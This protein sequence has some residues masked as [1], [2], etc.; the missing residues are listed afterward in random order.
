MNK[1]STENRS[2]TDV[3]FAW[4]YL[5]WGG[6]QMYF[7]GIARQIRGR[8]RV[9]FLFPVGTDPQFVGFC[10]DQGFEYSTLAVHSDLGPAISVSRRILRHFRKI[11][12]EYALVREIGR[13][14]TPGSP[15]HVEMTPWQSI[16]ALSVLCLRG[17]VFVTMHNRLPPVSAFR[18]T[19]WKFKF[20]IAA[21]LGNLH[22]FPSNR[23]AKESLAAYANKDFVSRAVVTYT[24][25]DPTEI[26]A[27]IETR[28][29]SGGRTRDVSGAPQDAF[30]VVTVG[31]FIDRKGRWETVEAAKLL[32]ASG[33]KVFFAWVNNS[34]VSDEDRAKLASYDIA[35]V[36]RLVSSADAGR[37][38][39]ELM[40]FLS[41]ADAFVLASHVEGLPISLLEAMAL[42]VPS[43]STRVNAIPEAVT[44]G[45]TGLLVPPGDPV[46]IA[47]AVMKLLENKELRQRL[48]ANGRAK[49]L[50][51]FTETEVAEIAW[52]EYSA[53]VARNR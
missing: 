49:V 39:L 33:A 12:A 14:R 48:A 31:Q 34:Q 17:P 41:G 53:S 10:D 9:R 35:D 26:S 5:E 42:G 28:S 11:R 29:V 38:H 13:L 8:A 50:S 3:I 47:E 27:A 19:L 18:A 2:S 52:R 16:A 44:D 51:E 7:L 46:A 20:A 23:D 6:A 1:Q 21:R 32:K 37:T 15:V 4:N 40:N 30:L 43:V 45:E 22:I 25:V 36:F 24:N